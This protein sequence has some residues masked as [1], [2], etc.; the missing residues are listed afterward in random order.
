MYYY[1]SYIEF[2]NGT[3]RYGI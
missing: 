2:S 1:K 3:L